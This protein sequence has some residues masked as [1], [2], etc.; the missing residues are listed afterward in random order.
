MGL[1]NTTTEWGSL[2]KDLH[3]LIAIGLLALTYLGLEQAGM[4]SGDVL[5]RMTHGVK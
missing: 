2:A 4:G 3:W 5:R 1:R